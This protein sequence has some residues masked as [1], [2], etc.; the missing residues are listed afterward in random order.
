MRVSGEPSEHSR[1][2]GQGVAR[3]CFR[4][5]TD[6]D[7]KPAASGNF[8]KAV[9]VGRIVTQKNGA[10]SEKRQLAQKGGDRG[11]LV[12]AAWPELDDHFADD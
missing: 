7:R 4:R 10:A 9:L 6:P 3:A 12:S 2:R 8:G 1:N 11:T 5:L